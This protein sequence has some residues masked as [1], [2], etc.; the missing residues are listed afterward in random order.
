[1]HACMY[2]CVSFELILQLPPTFSKIA[3]NYYYK[4]Y[5]GH[6]EVTSNLS[7][8]NGM[9]KILNLLINLLLGGVIMNLETISLYGGKINMKDIL[10]I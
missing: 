9:V 1:M 2:V 7:L 6:E 4:F 3:M 8:I 5:N 10:I